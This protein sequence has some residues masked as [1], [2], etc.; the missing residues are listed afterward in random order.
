M[1]M[2]MKTLTSAATARI[3]A[4]ELVPAAI[5]FAG[6]D[7]LFGYRLRRAQGAVHRDYLATLDELK[8]TQKQTAVM[9][10]VMAN[11]GVAQGAIG[12][13]LGMDR[14]TMMALVNRLE[15]RGLLQRRRSAVDARRRELQATA[16]GLRL[17]EQVRAR[18]SQHEDRVKR[19]FSAAELRTLERLLTRLQDLEMR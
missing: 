11:P 16:A 2:R 9:W 8:L 19:M 7:R 13:A 15:A 18:I 4:D 1:S 5:A 14:A 10:L 3:P 6:L 17:M 12:G